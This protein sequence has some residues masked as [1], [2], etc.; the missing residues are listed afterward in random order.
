MTTALFAAGAILYRGA[1]RWSLGLDN[2]N[3]AAALLAIAALVLL[4][5]ALRSKNRPCKWAFSALFA[6]AGFALLH[7]FS[8][9]GLAAFVAGAAILGLGRAWGRPV[10]WRAHAPLLAAVAAL[11]CAA[12]WIGFAGRMARSSLTSDASVANRLA[13]WEVAPRMMA[14]APG[15]WGLGSSGD[16]FMGWYQ[17]LDRH[18]RYRTLVNS[19]LTWLV[20]FGWPGRWVLAAAWMFALGCGIVRLKRR[21]DALPL[22]AMVCFGI[23]A[24]FS[25]VAEEWLVWPLPVAF[26]ALSAWTLV[27]S[28][29]PERVAVATCAAAG[30]LVLV[31]AFAVVGHLASRD[32]PT[33]HRSYDGRRVAFGGCEPTQWAVF[34]SATMGGET[35]GRALRAFAAED[36][37]ADKSYGIA[38]DIDA[39]PDSARRLAICGRAARAP[40]PL[41]RFRRLRELRILSP[42][43]PAAWCRLPAPCPVEVFCGDLS[44]SCPM[45]DVKG[46]TV[47]PGASVYLPDWPRL[48]FGR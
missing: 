30:G 6:T 21:G 45:E 1:E 8:R 22:A 23:S 4:E 39:V 12:L 40:I 26:A 17:P 25:S 35:F 34:D 13:I 9:G 48:A 41:E 32:L 27:Q 15:G 20:E 7:T 38:A 46:L 5:A 18:E 37:N 24:L 33:I 43:D 14:D 19:H 10:A 16:A 11:L 47:V 2:P 29:K 44:P 36:Q 3:K 31:G 28:P 42:E